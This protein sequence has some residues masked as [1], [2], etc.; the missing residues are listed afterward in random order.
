MAGAGYLATTAPWIGRAMAQD[1][2][3]KA[4]LGLIGIGS[5]GLYLMNILRNIPGADIV[6]F[7]D[8]YEPHFN[9]TREILGVTPRGYGDYRVMLEKEELDAVVIAT[10]LHEHAHMTIDALNAGLHV[11]CEKAM[12]PAIEDCNAMVE[13]HR[14]NNRILH[15]GHQRMFNIK[16]LQAMKDIEEGLIGKVTQIRAYWHMNHDWRRPVPSPELEKK[17]NW[18]LYEESSCGLMTELASHQIQ[19]ANWIL[20]EHPECAWGA[21][22]INHWKDGREVDDNV[23][24]VYKYPGGAHLVQ[25]IMLSNKKYGMEEQVLGPLGTLEL[26]G[27]LKFEEFPKPAP[28]I[29]QLINHLEHKLFDVVPIG[30]PSWVPD[31]PSE[32]K[33]EYILRGDEEMISD[34]SMMQ[35]E[36]FVANVIDNRVDTWITKEGFYASIAT[37]MGYEAMKKNEVVFWPE[38]LII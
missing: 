7:C 1:A 4:R 6:C 27:G 19:V 30:G 22:S 33:G 13:A 18:R 23:N 9:R 2:G 12:A 37:L 26:E 8:N 29:I 21:G 20:R 34:G 10:P 5:R 17:I 35:M 36:A 3:R 14:K 28:G 16:Y 31:T 38:N 15:I 32:D 11:L 24:L 25:D